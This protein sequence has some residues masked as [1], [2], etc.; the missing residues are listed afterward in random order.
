MTALKPGADRSVVTPKTSSIRQMGSKASPL[1]AVPS[2]LW[3]FLLEGG[4]EKVTR[5]SH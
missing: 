4:W 5:K 2:L 3:G 1:S